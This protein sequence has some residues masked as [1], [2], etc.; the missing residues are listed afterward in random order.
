MTAKRRS[1]VRHVLLGGLWLLGI[2]L[3]EAAPPPVSAIINVTVTVVAPACVINDGRPIEVDFG[4]DVITTRIDGSNYKKTVDYSLS[5]EGA[6]ANVMKMQ[7]KGGAASGGKWLS[8]NK[9]GLAIAFLNQG[10][11]LPVNTW[12]NFTW[13]DK[14]SL[15]AVPVMTG[16]K[17]PAGG[18]FSAGATM[19]VDYQ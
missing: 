15:Q 8:T 3:A 11:S 19:M 6:S 1:S 9:T 12:F 2:S 13:P 7:I 4:S 17:A 10:V 14:P 18:D 5:C 16:T